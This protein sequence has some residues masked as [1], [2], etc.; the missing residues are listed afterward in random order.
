[1][2][3]FAH[4][5]VREAAYAT[6][7][8]ADRA[9]GH[10][11]A[12]EWLEQMGHADAL[13]MAEHFRRGGEPARSARWYRRAA[14]QALEAS[15]LG[16]A[17]ERAELGAGCDPSPEDRGG[18]LLV[19]AEAHLWRGDLA[20]AE[21]RGL[22]AA[23]HLPVGSAAWFRAVIQVVNAAGKL[24]GTGRVEAWVDRVSAAI[25]AEGAA[26]TRITCL[27]GCAIHL[28]M[29]GRYA[30]ADALIAAIERATTGTPELDAET[31]A[32][33][34]Q[35]RS[36]L[37]SARGDLGGCLEACRAA[38]AAFEQA[39]DHRNACSI[40]GNLGFLFAELG[41]FDG[42]EKA[43]CSAQA[44]AFRLGLHN[45][46]AVAA[47]NLGHVLARLGRLDEA[48]RIEQGAVEVFQQQGERRLEGAARTYLAEIALL[49][50]DLDA[51]EREARAAAEALEVAPS[52]RPVAVALLG[53]V[54]IGLDRLPEALAAAGEAMAAL[55]SHG[56]L[57][58]G[59][60]TVRLVH[61][62]ALRASGRE[63]EFARAIA[64][65]RDQLLARAA[66]IGDPVWRERFL[67]GVG[68]NAETLALAA[69]CDA[70]ARC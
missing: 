68:E 29:G 45:L 49:A 1:Q 24:G 56:A 57:E 50:G 63:R 13:E 18:L 23:A 53:R 22:E 31:T 3:A 64:E 62:T 67:S 21:Q 15:D 12:A 38:L 28:L 10:W 5:L 42:A 39:E 46:A 34:H 44:V 52:L 61:A 32:V 26:G 60:T 66:K 37:A 20:L 9:L 11:L 19:E 17:I 33:I 35:V 41:D 2:Y 30:A 40:N 27:C 14:E 47:H 54:L 70:A 43:L 58:E 51:A 4:A 36:F 55:A 8:E 25:P 65:A 7:V 16:A 69:A 6:L 59:E 48:R